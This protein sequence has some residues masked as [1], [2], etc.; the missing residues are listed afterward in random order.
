MTYKTFITS[1]G[2]GQLY[3]SMAPLSTSVHTVG[4]AFIVGVSEGN[5]SLSVI[6][7][8]VTLPAGEY[9][10]EAYPW[11]GGSGQISYQWHLDSGSGFSAVGE[12]GKIQTKADTSDGFMNASYCRATVPDGSTYEIELRVTALTGTVTDAG[13]YIVAWRTD[14]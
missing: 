13:G 8:T 5:Y 10:F 9:M 2:Q 3:L 1:G 4:T 11:V 12:A 7:G 14:L 6:G